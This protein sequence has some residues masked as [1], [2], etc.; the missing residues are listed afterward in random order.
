MALWMP[1]VTFTQTA[2]NI[3]GGR[4]VFLPVSAALAGALTISSSQKALIPHVKDI[5]IHEEV[6]GSDHC[7]VELIFE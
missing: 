1:T 5:V 4:I 6:L 3:R 2:S 7:P